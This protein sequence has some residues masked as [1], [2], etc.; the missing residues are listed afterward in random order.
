MVTLDLEKAYD[1]IWING[2]LY[3]LIQ[4]EFAAYLITFLFS[5]LRDRTFSVVI[6]GAQST[7]RTQGAGLPQGAALSPILFTYYISDIPRLQH[8]HMA[9]YADDTALLTQSWR[10]D[11][12]ARR[13]TSAITHLKKYFDRWRLKLN[14][15]K[16]EAILFT[17]RRPLPPPV[18]RIE[19]QQLQWSS[20]VKYLGLHLTTSLTFTTQ[21]RQAA[22][23]ALG[24]LA[25]IFPLLARDSSL[26]SHTKLR[27]YMATIR[28]MLT[29]GAS[30][31]CSISDSNFLTLQTAQNK[32]LRVIAD[33]PRNTPIAA[34]HELLGV[35]VIQS[36][37]LRLATSFYNQC[38]HHSNHLIRGIGNYSGQD[39]HVMYRMYTHKRTKH[40]LL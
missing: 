39:L 25:R 11:T 36:Y 38:K 5:Y 18:L 23:A 12:V 24:V 8:I 32:C 20:E 10:V 22:H 28:P 7:P 30:V 27:L 31:W 34:L 6:N 33:A 14:T 35:E 1:T 40:R 2:L 16:T 19:G 29:Y 15:A 37:A 3:K 13:L 4:K 17:K 26:S 21:V 9:L